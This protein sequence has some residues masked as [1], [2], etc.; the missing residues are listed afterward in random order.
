MRQIMLAAGLCMVA[1]AAF[2]D[3]M[4]AEACAAK[5]SAEARTIYAAVAPKVVP[6]VSLREVV[7]EQTR[8]LV[9]AGAVSKATA[10]TAAEKAG[11]CL[12]KIAP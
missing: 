5:L 10:R 8:A 9:I 12:E 3:K 11:M 1:T 6:G 7:T 2:A 4:A